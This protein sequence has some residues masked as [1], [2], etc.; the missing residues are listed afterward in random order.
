MLHCIH[1]NVAFTLFY[2]NDWKFLII[3]LNSDPDIIQ[4]NDCKIPAERDVNV[5]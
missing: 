2:K 1:S 5:L 4:G 3:N